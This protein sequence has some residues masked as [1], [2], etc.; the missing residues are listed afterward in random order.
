MIKFLLQGDTIWNDQ[1][2]YQAMYSGKEKQLTL[3]KK[4]PVYI[5]YF[6]SFVDEEGKLNFRK[7]IYNRDENL[8]KL[9][10]KP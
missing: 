4:I 1:K 5:V 10:L 7:D 3:A 6:T 8:K 9:I 2:I